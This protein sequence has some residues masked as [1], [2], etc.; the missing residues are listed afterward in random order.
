MIDEGLGKKKVALSWLLFQTQSTAATVDTG[1]VTPAS[2]HSTAG[3][4]RSQ[5]RENL[6]RYLCLC[7]GKLTQNKVVA[8][9]EDSEERKL[10]L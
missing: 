7:L 3:L 6:M 10:V 2:F 1:S 4:T 8:E 5:K 9:K